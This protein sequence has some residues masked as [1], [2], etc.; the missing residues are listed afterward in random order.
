[1]KYEEVARGLFRLTLIWDMGIA[2]CPVSTFLVETDIAHEW[3]MVDAGFDSHVDAILE[4]VKELLGTEG[5]LT[6]LVVTHGHLD[7]IAAIPKLLEVYPQMK[8]CTAPLEKPFLVDG[9]KYKSLTGDS[10]I[11]SVS[12]YLLHEGNV[13]VPEDRY[14]ELIDGQVLGSVL[15]VHYTPGHTPGSTSYLHVPSKSIMVG[16]ALMFYDAFSK[17][18]SCQILKVSTVNY[19]SALE[20]LKKVMTLDINVIYP[21]HDAGD[22]GITIT[23]IEKFLSAQ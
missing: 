11:F 18:P 12:K 7:H 23:D 1:M 17:C 2:K 13:K 16:D 3:I 20:S 21:A 19:A 22:K 15:K 10:W 8:V 5:K 14:E 4:G 9:K 6:R